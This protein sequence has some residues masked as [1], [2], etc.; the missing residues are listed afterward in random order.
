M[1]PSEKMNDTDLLIARPSQ[2]GICDTRPCKP[3][4]HRRWAIRHR[5]RAAELALDQRDVIIL[6]AAEP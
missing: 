5:S 6:K 3:G 4:V 2:I 1:L